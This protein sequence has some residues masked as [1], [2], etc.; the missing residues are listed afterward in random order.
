MPEQEPAQRRGQFMA[1]LA[2]PGVVFG[3][4]FVG[5]AWLID[6]YVHETG[7]TISAL[8]KIHQEDPLLLVL[9]LTPLAL[10]WMWA[11][12]ERLEY[13]TGERAALKA[14]A[15]GR[16][17]VEALVDAVVDAV[18]LVDPGGRV[19]EVNQAA[20][21]L[22]GMSAVALRG[23]D[24]ATL[25]PEHTQLNAERRSLERSERGEVLGVLWRMTALHGDGTPFSVRVGVASYQGATGPVALYVVRDDA[26]ERVHTAELRRRSADELRA[27]SRAEWRAAALEAALQDALGGGSNSLRGRLFVGLARALKPPRRSSSGA[28]LGPTLVELAGEHCVVQAGARLP[29]LDLDKEDLH[30]LIAI[31][32]AALD[33]GDGARLHVAP[34]TYQGRGWVAVTITRDVDEPLWRDPPALERLH[35]LPN[36]LRSWTT[37]ELWLVTLRALAESMGGAVM[38]APDSV[39]GARVVVRLPAVAGEALGS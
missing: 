16:V 6:A 12:R 30:E 29:L 3:L 36:S 33:G 31:A 25:L 10:G 18:L 4:V 34:V 15:A 24:V 22:F 1:F 28:R 5:V 8:W 17:I 7:Y 11:A 35:A 26:K 14:D 21:R 20:E 38:L 27:T 19:V 9:D 2:R 32:V 39:A 37:G 13:L 23:R